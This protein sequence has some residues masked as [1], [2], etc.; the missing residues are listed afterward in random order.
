MDIFW[1]I[2]P[3]VKDL[4]DFWK[5]NL[6]YFG[7]ANMQT[8]QIISAIITNMSELETGI[9]EVISEVGG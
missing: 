6:V 8:G 1:K 3:L 7:V 4:P 2:S 9:R 5:D